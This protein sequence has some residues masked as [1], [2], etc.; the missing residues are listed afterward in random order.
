MKP[1]LLL[2]TLG[3][4]LL[5]GGEHIR[6]AGAAVLL[7]YGTNLARVIELEINYLP[8]RPL[9]QVAATTDARFVKRA[10]YQSEAAIQNVLQL[11]RFKQRGKLF[12]TYDDNRI[13][14]F[15]VRE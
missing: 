8:D 5:L 14:S 13:L 2:G 11:A 1:L 4:C 15:F 10:E 6:P 9:L 12:I 3:V 7:Q